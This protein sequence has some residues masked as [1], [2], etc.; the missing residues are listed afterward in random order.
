[1]NDNYHILIDKLDA[2]IRKYY[3]NQLIK[4]GL[5][6]IALLGSFF[7]IFTFLESLAWFPPL[8]RSILFFSYIAGAL[9]IITWF[10]IIPILKL[11]KAGPRISHAMAA[12]IIGKHFSEVKD[13]LL[14]TLQLNSLID[15]DEKN[16]DLIIASIN[17]KAES[18]KPIPFVSAI[19]LKKNS[20]YLYFAAPPLFIL[21]AF[22]FIAPTKITEP[23]TRLL[24][25]STP[26]EKPLPFSINITNKNLQAVQLEDFTI[27]IRLSGEELPNQVSIL[28]DGIEYRM[29]ASDK[30]NYSYTFRKLQTTQHFSFIAA[31]F[32]TND[33]ELKVLPRPI[34]LNFDLELIYPP[35]TGKKSELLTNTGD[36]IIPQGTSILWKYYTRDTRSL[37]FRFGN[38]LETLKSSAS[39]TI[40]VSRRLMQP[41]SYSV[42]IENE[43]MKGADSMS[44]F[45]NVLPDLYP[46]INVEEFHD[47]I[48]DNRLYF[49]GLLKD[50]YGF[51]NLEFRLARKNANGE[52]S[53]EVS[54]PIDIQKANLQQQFYYYFDISSA[55]LKPGEEV[56]YYF[57]VW[58]N[59][60]VNGSKSSRSQRMSFKIPTLEEIETMVSKNQE[61][62]K[63]ELEKGIQ[64]A[65]KIQKDID[66]LTKDLFDKKNLNY[67][68]KKKIQD[69]LDRQKNL[70]NQVNE[71]KKQNKESNLKESQYKEL[72]QE[73][74]EKQQQLE[75]LFNEIMTDEMRKLFDELQKMMENLDKDKLNEVMEKMKFN[76]E[77]MEK[78]LDRNLELFKQLEF[79]K[80]LTETIE[81]LKQLSDEQEK[82]SEKSA[83]ADKKDLD[84]LTEKQ[85][86]INKE[87]EQI[88]KDL[89]DLKE[90]NEKLEDPNNY[91]N[92][93][94]QQ[95]DIQKELNDS[96]KNLK[97]SK[98]K[99]ASDSQKKAS[100]KM[101]ELSEMLFQMQQEMEEESM[102]EDIESLRAILENLVRISFDQEELINKLGQ[103]Q[104]N[105]PQFNK[106]VELQKGIQDNLQMV[107]DSLY[108][109][110]KRQPMI[111][112]IV[113]REISTINDNVGQS[114]DA[115]NSR[116]ISSAMGKQQY[117]MTSVN[118][119]ALLLAESM[120]EMKQNMS[121][122][123]SSKSG[124]SCPNPGSGKPS[125]KSMRQMQ[126]KLNQQM[127]AM[128]KSLKEGKGEKGK[129]GQGSMSEQLARMAAQQES[130]RKQMQEYRDQLQ[131]EGILSE[132]G[133]NKMLQDME[134][135]ETDLV[136]KI[137]NQETMQRQQEIL[138]R[139]LE[140]EKAEL[141]RDQEERR[142]S[143]QGR[144]LPKPDPAKYFENPALPVRETE[145]LRTIPPTLRD[146]YRNKVNEYFLNIPGTGS[147]KSN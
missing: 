113:N 133:L 11:Y 77:D 28:L 81:K 99:K 48:Y 17:Q 118:N 144:D 96:E 19:D 10:V 73:I 27:N 71:L 112:S 123:S 57:Q 101:G 109:L 22:L 46:V 32:Q 91:K 142:E 64:E 137:L 72:N 143:N 126:E 100:E 67:Q 129:S 63:N 111:E 82:L 20:K 68:E 124:K 104:R 3:T 31:G 16:K 121:M 106:V 127:E 147:I 2:F 54:M 140:S 78:S 125:M 92:P 7:L 44:F 9:F 135:T 1:M 107:E 86:S 40:T 29:E 108:A 30:L 65:K 53:A 80:K 15:S 58:D 130:L 117:V 36:V 102:G 24:H 14:N 132:K 89:K 114:L 88:K 47:S 74:V 76:A 49:R 87:F 12:Q 98:S 8:V 145:L 115:L 37:D 131:K 42:T 75:K 85:E 122:K 84:N 41:V 25:Y 116:A 26:F 45:I 34:I 94:Q 146:Y 38:T 59:D 52:P 21:I 39:N 105:D 128:K 55:G 141:K 50:D 136:N 33:Y 13:T 61:N 97:E 51:R 6:S 43:Y 95:E 134:Q 5:Y 18:L 110:S 62:V 93:E 56:E 79:D 66:Q 35:Y 120:K 138:T 103:L 4:G 90:K 70:Q 23:S 83:G 60:G 69:L 139:L 119:L